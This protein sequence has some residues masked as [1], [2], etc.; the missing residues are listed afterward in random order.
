M[1]GQSRDG[2]KYGRL[3]SHTIP[4]HAGRQ[5]LA[6]KRLRQRNHISSELERFEF[7]LNC[8]CIVTLGMRGDDVMHIGTTAFTADKI[9]AVQISNFTTVS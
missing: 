2:L 8:S 1:I 7:T 9:R 5:P 4:A 6:I 3:N